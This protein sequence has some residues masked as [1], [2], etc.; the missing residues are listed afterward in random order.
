[1]NGAA[2]GTGLIRLLLIPSPNFDIWLN[3]NRWNSIAASRLKEIT[4]TC[5]AVNLIILS[6]KTFATDRTCTWCHVKDFNL[7]LL[8]AISDSKQKQFWGYGISNTQFVYFVERWKNGRMSCKLLV[9]WSHVMQVMHQSIETPTLWV[10]GKGGGF[11]IDPSQ[12]A[13]ISLPPEAIV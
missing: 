1:M 12:K 9:K 7:T 11:D 5:W 13:S 4:A 8:P 10:P 2:F 3:S 6:S